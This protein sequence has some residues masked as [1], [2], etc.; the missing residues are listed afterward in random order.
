[1]EVIKDYMATGRINR[2]GT[3]NSMKY[4]TIH[5]TANKSKGANA[6]SHAN[7]I[8]TIKDC[9]SWHYTVDDTSIYQHIPDNEKSYH[10]SDK[11]ANENSIAVEICVN[12]DGDFAK[13]CENAVWLVRELMDRYNIP[14]GNVVT[15]NYW[16]EKNC[17]A[18]LLKNGLADFIAACAIKDVVDESADI[19]DIEE[20]IPSSPATEAPDDVENKTTIEEKDVLFKWKLGSFTIYAVR[21][22][23]K[24]E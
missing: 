21:N 15:H 23:I 8:K 11:Y 13:A 17:P 2:P 12:E 1:M 7:Y 6:K 10:T 9:T 20:P 14:I 5:D 24:D 4:I 16:T 18:S 22:K 19:L 3:A